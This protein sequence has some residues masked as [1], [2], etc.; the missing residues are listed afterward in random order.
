[1]Q[2]VLTHLR[3][4]LSSAGASFRLPLDLGFKICFC[5]DRFPAAL[6]GADGSIR[7]D[8]IAE[9]TVGPQALDG[10]NWCGRSAFQPFSAEG[11]F[12]LHIPTLK[13]R[14]NLGSP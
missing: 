5:S 8:S 2:A 13:Y 4:E 10:N 14:E 9:T 12:D 1:M 3:L 11:D 7:P 6:D